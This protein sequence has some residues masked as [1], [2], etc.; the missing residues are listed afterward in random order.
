MNLWLALNGKTEDWYYKFRNYK[1]FWL[2][3]KYV[4][5]G[6]TAKV[7]LHYLY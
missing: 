2:Q 1:F 3:D 6:L 7:I 4:I 5:S